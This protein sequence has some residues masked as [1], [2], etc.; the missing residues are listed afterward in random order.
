MKKAFMV[1]PAF[2]FALLITAC[3]GNPAADDKALEPA[4]SKPGPSS[5]VPKGA[6]DA[7]EIEDAE[8]TTYIGDIKVTLIGD[9]VVLGGVDAVKEAVTGIDI[10]A[11][12]DRQLA[13][14]GLDLL[15]KE[16]DE[17]KLGDIVVLAL[18]TSNLTKDDIE[19]AME[20]I[21]PERQVVLV[22]AYRGNSDY[23]NKVNNAIEEAAKNYPSNFNIA[24]WYG[25]IIS[26]PDIKLASDNCH[27][28]KSSAKDYAEVIKSGV[29]AA[30]SRLQN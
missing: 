8:S 6:S 20:V 4:D 28:T 7:D 13:G 12:N 17:G 14:P 27:L 15:K 21:G 18:G 19:N 26:H 30:A 22:T 24:D 1:L 10:R 9:S 25:Y 23:I 3:G 29:E 11:R 16:K 2:L 5:A